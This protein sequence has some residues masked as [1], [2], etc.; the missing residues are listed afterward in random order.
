MALN[1]VQGKIELKATPIVHGAHPAV[2][3]STQFKASNGEIKAGAIIALNSS[4][5]ALLYERGGTSPINAIHGV[6][7]EDVNTAKQTVGRVLIHGAVVSK[8]VLH[9]TSAATSADFTALRAAGI[10]AL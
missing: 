3:V 4:S 10:Y 6:L 9:K 5:E 8:K 1:A 7:I 2:V